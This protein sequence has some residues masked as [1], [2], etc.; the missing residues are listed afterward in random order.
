MI[1][2]W[3]IRRELLRLREQAHDLPG[4]IRFHLRRR[5]EARRRIAHDRDFAQLTTL[6]EGAIPL[7]EK[8]A[9]FLLYQPSG[10]SASTF[11]TCDWLISHDYAPVLVSNC[12][13]SDGDRERS[14][15]RFALLL[16]RPNFGRDFG[17]YRDA[18]LLLQRMGIAPERVIIM[19]DSIWVPMTEGVMERLEAADADIVGLM[20]NEKAFRDAS[21]RLKFAPRFLESHFLLLK[22]PVWEAPA[23]R[24]YWHDYKMTDEKKP[25]M[26][27]GERG[28]SRAMRAAG[29]D[30]RG[31]AGA[32]ALLEHL[33][34]MNDRD[35][36][37]VLKYAV[38]GAPDLARRG[39]RLASM[40]PHD[41]NWRARVLEHVAE[42]ISRY[43]CL[44]SFCH[45]GATAFGT[46]FMKKTEQPLWK[47][48]RRQYLRAVRD[49]A[50]PA[51]PPVI[52]DEIEARVRRDFPDLD[53]AH[54][55]PGGFVAG[56]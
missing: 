10:I 47:W 23:F 26:R 21:G 8:A 45:A 53:Q 14:R 41:R 27:F 9:I 24:T 46:M 12:K 48:Q 5:E 22:R 25:T 3:K 18:I 50:L 28:F 44:G 55:A 40:S 20:Q 2:A 31:L 11:L 35:L 43:H 49:G 16:E 7:G 56:Q 34:V 32:T 1:P 13:V 52:L 51:P 4:V 36:A 38:H 37:L 42:T 54:H 39:A 33:D 6:H 15:G 30:L 17:G 29:F 19:N